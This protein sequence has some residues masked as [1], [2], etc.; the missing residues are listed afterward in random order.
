M[1]IKPA[2]QV[3]T[4]GVDTDTVGTNR[5]DGSVSKRPTH[6]DQFCK[7]Y[8]DVLN[9]EVFPPH[10]ALN[11]IS[12]YFQ[13]LLHNAVT[14]VVF[15]LQNWQ[16]HIVKSMIICQKAGPNPATTHIGLQ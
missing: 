10:V 15:L 6:W 14:D 7:D 5:D 4:I 1:L 8:A 13:V 12:S 9:G 2:S 3:A 16:K 11:T